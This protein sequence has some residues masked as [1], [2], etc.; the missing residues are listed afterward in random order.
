MMHLLLKKGPSQPSPPSPQ[1]GGLELVAPL[2]HNR[3][4]SVPLVFSPLVGEMAGRPEGVFR[5]VLR[6]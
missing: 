5:R 1:G 6:P 4:S 3:T 2:S